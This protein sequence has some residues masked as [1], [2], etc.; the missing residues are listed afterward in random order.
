MRSEI[1]F[2]G[3]SKDAWL[4]LV[5]N[6]DSAMNKDEAK[7][8]KE[9]KIVEKHPDGRPK[10]MYSRSKMPMM[11]D[12]ENLL[13]LDFKDIDEKTYL[14][15]INNIEHPDYP[16]RKDAIRMEMFKGSLLKEVEGGILIREYSN[17]NLGGYF[18]S[19]LLNRMMSSMI[20]K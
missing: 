16:R 19:F 1:K 4:K 3:V 15:I 14:V 8:I 12:R 18:P 7:H 5:C 17:F 20:G 9:M 13:S 6:F 2:N 10:I 11:T